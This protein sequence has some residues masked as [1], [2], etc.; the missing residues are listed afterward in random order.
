MP[1]N[2]DTK[3]DHHED[4]D[5]GDDS[6]EIE[7]TKNKQQQ[8]NLDSDKDGQS[9][10]GSSKLIAAPT[11]AS[12][13][14]GLTVTDTDGRT[15]SKSPVPV[16]AKLLY[17]VNT[18]YMR[19]RRLERIAQYINKEEGTVQL[20]NLVAWRKDAEEI[21]SQ[22]EREHSFIEEACPSSFVTNPY[23]DADFHS[24]MHEQ[25]HAILFNLSKLEQ[26]W[27]SQH[28]DTQTTSSGTTQ[29]MHTSKLPDIA[30][31][32]FDGVYAEWP[33]FKEIFTGLILKRE[34][35]DNY[36]KLRYLRSSL[37]GAPLTL[38]QGFSLNQESLEP[39][40]NTL[41]ARYENKRSHLNDQLDQMANL[42]AA[43]PKNPASLNTLVTEMSKIRKSLIMVVQREDLGDCI[44]AH[45]MSRLVDRATR[46]AWETS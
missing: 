8:L 24:S 23:F 13:L 7:E 30:L 9:G 26:L 18:Q 22:Y 1:L 3:E 20:S 17:K 33:T 11:I 10:S 43:Q 4:S 44:L 27:N 2:K 29:V 21:Y 25:Y 19:L 38:I 12:M 32:S 15:R 14:T 37:K 6:K 5:S 16:P 31:P 41:V 39:A 40:W 34:K 36:A 42:A 45:R 28:K 35:L 46:K